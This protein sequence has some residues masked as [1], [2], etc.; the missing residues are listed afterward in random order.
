MLL[1]RPIFQESNMKILEFLKGYKTYFIVLCITLITVAYAFNLID[2]H[3]FT[4]LMG[5]FGGG[6]LAA[7]RHGQTSETEKL[8]QTDVVIGT[9]GNLEE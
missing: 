2:E 7:L 3:A 6:G 4:I 9:D 8:L 1:V 5:L